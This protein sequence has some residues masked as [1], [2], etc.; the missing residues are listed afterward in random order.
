MPEGKRKFIADCA[1]LL[2]GRADVLEAELE[3][4][5]HKQTQAENAADRAAFMELRHAADLIECLRRPYR[6]D[7]YTVARERWGKGE[8]SKDAW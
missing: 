7:P 1:A 8:L 5:R 2:R 3:R 6:G 4:D